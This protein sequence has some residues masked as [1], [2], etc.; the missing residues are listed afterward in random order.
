MRAFTEG[1]APHDGVQLPTKV[2]GCSCREDDVIFEGPAPQLRIGDYLVFYAVGAYNS[3]MAPDF[4]Y[5]APG[6]VFL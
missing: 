6:T 4:I 3:N 5:N 1:F 2:F